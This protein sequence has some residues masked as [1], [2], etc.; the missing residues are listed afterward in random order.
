LRR[1]SRS[2]LELVRIGQDDRCVR[3]QTDIVRKRPVTIDPEPWRF[4]GRPRVLIEHPDA[5]A[6]LDLATA[7]RRAGCTVAICR[8]PDA[9]ADPATRCPLHRLEPCAVV[10][11]ADVV[12]T[13]L[14]F[15]R[16]D[17]REVLRGLRTRYPST[18]LVI[19]ATVAETLELE[20]ELA[21]CTVVPQD[22]DPDRVAAAVKG[23]V[24]AAT[25]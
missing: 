12:V 25:R 19:E 11:G 14:G 13:A 21:G 2:A 3:R 18:P 22:A 8:G 24:A 17:A 5:G 9:T 6:G 23:V 15:D 1:S 16:E 20:D 10:E 7:L 4:S